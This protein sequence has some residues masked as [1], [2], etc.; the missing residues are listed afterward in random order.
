MDNLTSENKGAYIINK[1]G[2]N[3]CYCNAGTNALLSSEKITS[4]IRQSHCAICDFLFSM[5]NADPHSKYST[6]PLKSFVAYFKHEFDTNEQQD[7]D[8]FV[9]C[10]LSKCDIL[11]KLT[12]SVLHVKYTCK[13]CGNETDQQEEMNTLYESLNGDS[14]AEI[15][16]STERK[17]YYFFK[18]CEPCATETCHVKIEKLLILP[19]VL[20]INLKRFNQT[21]G[22]ITKDCKDIEPSSLLQIDETL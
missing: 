21:A 2:E 13:R 12:R 8:E 17:D 4:E 19:D 7:S 1:I 15:L 22:I 20:I 11:K 10:L 5:K 6:I 3:L 16:S 14:I 9:Q 18:S